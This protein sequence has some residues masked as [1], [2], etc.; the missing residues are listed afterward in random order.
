MG[1]VERVRCFTI[2][3][4][5]DDVVVRPGVLLGAPS[6]VD[7]RRRHGYGARCRRMGACDAFHLAQVW[8]VVVDRFD[9]NG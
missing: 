5:T 1:T 7:G 2:G 4:S 3:P 9:D 6:G 8:L